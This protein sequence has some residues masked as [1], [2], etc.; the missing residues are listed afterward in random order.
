MLYSA[1]K[2]KG[3][4]F[5]CVFKVTKDCEL[6]NI[7]FFKTEKNDKVLDSFHQN[8]FRF[9]RGMKKIEES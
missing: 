5:W 6:Q 3:Y 4:L 2:I 8:N 1:S 7:Q 9:L